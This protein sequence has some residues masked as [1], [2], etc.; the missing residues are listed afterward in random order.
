MGGAEKPGREESNAP[1][2]ALLWALIAATAGATY[3][4]WQSEE[5]A[6]AARLSHWSD[7]VQRTLSDRM[8]AY[9]QVLRGA[10]ALF[11]LGPEVDRKTWR[12]YAERLELDQTYPGIQGIGFSRWIR[13]DEKA[14]RENAIRADGY[15][16]YAIRPIGERSMY[17]AI[18]FLE[19]MRDRNLRAIG[20]DMYSEPVRREAMDR[21]LLSGA[22]ALSGKITLVQENRR[23]QQSGCQL[24]LP[25]YRGDIPLVTD[26]DRRRAL[27]GFAFSPFRMGDLM[28][29]ALANTPEVV[30]VSLYD[31]ES[32]APEALLFDSR[33][34]DEKS[35]FRRNMTVFETAG[36]RWT[37]VVYSGPEGAFMAVH[38]RSLAVAGSG[39]IL[40]ILSFFFIRSVAGG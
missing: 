4:F 7:A 13:P 20:Y 30:N 38:S 24:Y 31:G 3:A 16:S 19:P 32:D 27:I 5:R 26:D 39:L 37:L 36:R 17:T 18:E 29:A 15:P 28:T 11:V 33:P 35:V 12:I 2:W 14:A 1:A 40:A 25:I 34:A 6:E 10:A 8:D 23:A 9:T 21:A 22:P